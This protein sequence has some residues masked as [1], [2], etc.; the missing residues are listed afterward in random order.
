M[1]NN[2]LNDNK[3]EF[4]VFKSKHNAN[5]FAERNIHVGGTKVW[6]KNLGV[7]FDQ[8]LSMQAHVNT[9]APKNVLIT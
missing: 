8:I 4:I 1:N 7:A 3:T 2:K 9:I 6:I 5:T